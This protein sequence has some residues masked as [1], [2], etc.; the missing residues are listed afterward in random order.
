ME[1]L[2]TL[3]VLGQE[4]SLYTDAPEEDVEEILHLVKTSLET[5]PHSAARLPV[6]K[7]AILTC[8]NMAGEYVKLKRHFEEYKQK[9][10]KNIDN[11]TKRIETSL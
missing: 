7:V 11:L 8:L 6:N 3:E 1:R 10:L 9:F 4:Y 2:V 5:Q